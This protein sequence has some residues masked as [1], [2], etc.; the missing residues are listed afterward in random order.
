M[1]VDKELLL[2]IKSKGIGDGEP[3]LGEELMKTFLNVL[4]ESEIMCL[5]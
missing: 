5:L 3:K 4:L 2:L 1:A